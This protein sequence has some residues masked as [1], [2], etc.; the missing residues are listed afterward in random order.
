MARKRELPVIGR[1]RELATAFDLV[2]AGMSVDVVGG[3]G[4]GRSA[5]L[6]ALRARLEGEDW[7]V[8]AVRG[9][10]SLRTHASGA[11]HL[12]GI[13]EPSPRGMAASLPD[14]ALALTEASRR[15]RSVL[16]VDDWDDLDESFWG[17][18]ESVRRTTRVATVLTRLRGL[19]VRHT[20]SGLTA[21]SLEPG[22]LIEL[23]PLG[24]DELERIVTDYL[25]GPVEADTMSS[26]FGRSGGS[27]GLACALVDACRREG[28]LVRD[29]PA[30]AGSRPGCCGAPG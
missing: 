11:L 27:T 29:A 30:R 17:V 23:G 7:T 14:A 8:V 2:S 16:F 15:R 22:Y 21:S 10:A 5:F 12:A 25:G 13:G 18:I 20:P 1:E 4:S 6:A 19:R 24:F 3:R 28:K 26:V 9:I